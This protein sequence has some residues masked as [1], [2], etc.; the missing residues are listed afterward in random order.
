MA[1]AHTAVADTTEDGAFKR[2][3]AVFRNLV[4]EGGEFPP[5]G[6]QR[7]LCRCTLSAHAA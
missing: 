5:A 1:A 4:A 3:P 6:A 7:S 2:Q